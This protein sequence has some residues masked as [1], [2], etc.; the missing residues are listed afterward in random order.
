MKKTGMFLLILLLVAG[1]LGASVFWLGWPWQSQPVEEQRSAKKPTTHYTPRSTGQA[2][3]DLEVVD[4]TPLSA[5]IPLVTPVEPRPPV[6]INVNELHHE[7]ASFPFVDLFRQASP[8]TDNVL[9]LDNA[10]QAEYDAQ[11]WPIRLNGGVAATKFLGKMP[12]EALPPGDLVVLYDGK[13]KLEYGHGVER[14]EQQRGREV[15]R[16]HPGETGKLNA[17]LIVTALDEQD[18]IRNIRILLPGGI[19]QNQPY[20]WVKGASQCGSKGAGKYLPFERYYQSIVFNPA[21]LDFLKD[22]SAIRLMPMSGITR[23]PER[24]WH[25]R[26]HM[27][28]ATWGG[29]YGERGAPLEI[30]VMLAN[31]L[32]ADAWFNLPHAADD[33]YVRRFARYV[34]D[35]LDPELNIYIE[36]TNEV[37]NTAFSHSEYTQKKGIEAEYSVNAVEAGYQY[38]IQRAGEIFAIWEEVFGSLERLTR[39]LGSWDTRPDISR[40]LLGEYGGYKHADAL[41]IAPYFG[42]NIKGFREAETVDDIFELTTAEDSFRSLP[43]VLDHVRTQVEVAHHYGVQLLA[44]EGGQGLVDWATR[45]PDEHPNPLFFAA[46]RDERMGKLYT[47]MLKG[48]RGAGGGLYMVFASPRTCQWFGC[49]GIKEHI[50]QAA[51]EAPKYQAV[52]DF[53]QANRDWVVPSVKPFDGQTAAV[54]NPQ[55]APKKPRGPDDPVIVFRPARDPER[56]FLLE[57]PQTLDNL[58]VGETWE[59]RNLFGKWQAKWDKDYLYLTV[60]VY[61]EDVVNDSTRP[62]HDDSVELYIDGDNSRLSQYDGRNDFRMTFA[63]G[64]EQV[65]IDPK[66]PQYIH[67]D[68]AFDFVRNED[69]YTLNVLLPWEMLGV[70]V[71]VKHRL[72]VD[73]QVNDDDDGGQRER[74]VSWIAR[75]DNAMNDPRLLGVVLISGR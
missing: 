62:E 37:W 9:E 65:I 33:D 41:A 2:W 67:P 27:Q 26:P 35:N 75:E 1:V 31:R 59:K 43:E 38:Y 5:E 71:D 61:D 19:C 70:D 29:D 44:Y 68:L 18:P 34:R 36:Y 72:G 49:W 46:N 40:K 69:G 13:G 50:R 47:E 45:E 55:L 64:R 20:Q 63:W 21:Y 10:A 60:R 4:I 30:Q 15:I 22:F 52:L 7:D 48:W 39:V 53:I 57:N 16:L 74:K 17:S 24:Y 11:G 66:S 56:Y 32:Q 73:I 28:E 23:N 25:E 54:S 42:G 12:P 58:L 51:A 6:G 8:F 3:E 14:I